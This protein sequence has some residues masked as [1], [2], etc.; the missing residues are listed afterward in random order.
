MI[1]VLS[2]DLPILALYCSFSQYDVTLVTDLVMFCML[3]CSMY[4]RQPANAVA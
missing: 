2:S 1:F 3:F 4:I